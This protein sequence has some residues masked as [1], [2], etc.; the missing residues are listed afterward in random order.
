M[1]PGRIQVF[2]GLRVTTEHMEHF[3]DSL[4]SALEDIREVLGVGIVHLGF[5]VQPQGEQAV[6]VGP[7]I[8]FDYHR[9]RVVCDEPS[10][11]VV[12][13]PAG[14]DTLYLCAKY[15]EVERGQVEGR[16]TLLWDSC[17]LHLHPTLPIPEDNLVL[18]A[19][20][21]ASS[22]NGRGFQIERL[23]GPPETLAAAAA[24]AVSAAAPSA[25]PSGAP[26]RGRV[27]IVRLVVRLGGEAGTEASGRTV[28]VAALR[29]LLTGGS[30]GQGDEVR[31]PLAATEVPLTFRPFSLATDT[32]LSASLALGTPTPEAAG[33]PGARWTWQATAHGEAIF[34]D[35]V[36]TQFGLTNA[37]VRSDATDKRSTRS[38]PPD[39]SLASVARL[40]LA[41][42][43]DAAEIPP[44]SRSVLRQL[45]LRTQVS[46][47]EETGFRISTV[48]VWTGDVSEEAIQ[49]VDGLMQ[50]F[51]WG[52]VLAW[53]VLG[54]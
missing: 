48:I 52:M 15:E 9:N 4:H 35:Q 31:V 30:R 18:I 14:K 13:F 16:P 5:D 24:P 28:L 40:P 49:T 12:A 1:K 17:S 11:V 54:A 23:A 29:A 20:L 34:D 37:Q 32:V 6:V 3:Q 7:G 2:D 26:P 36:V 39:L 41:L 43:R 47:G 21:K 22:G 42:D 33:A 46:E 27:G 50:T 51:A 44:L 45:S 25:A 10:Q 53:K 8:A 19:R 38:V